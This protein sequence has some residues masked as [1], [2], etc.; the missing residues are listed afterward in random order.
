MD[1]STSPREEVTWPYDTSSCVSSSEPIAYPILRWNGGFHLVHNFDE[2]IVDLREES[3]WKIDSS[4]NLENDTQTS[5]LSNDKQEKQSP[6]LNQACLKKKKKKNDTKNIFKNKSSGKEDQLLKKPLPVWNLSQ[7]G[8]VVKHK[9]PPVIVSAPKKNLN[10]SNKTPTSLKNK[11]T[12]RRIT[13]FENT[14]MGCTNLVNETI[15][16]KS[17]TT[18]DATSWNF[19]RLE[20]SSELSLSWQVHWN[21]HQLELSSELSCLETFIL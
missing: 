9:K 3:K 17:K 13:L 5:P 10:N 19:H 20:H 8:H 12:L 1:G 18:T 2:L 4:N 11:T 16:Q 7:P 15:E 21:F 14:D 6:T